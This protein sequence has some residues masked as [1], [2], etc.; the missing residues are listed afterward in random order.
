MERV[1]A[2]EPRPFGSGAEPT[3]AAAGQGAVKMM[4]WIQIFQSQNFQHQ[5]K[6]PQL[7]ISRPRS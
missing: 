2:Y 1:R 6:S 3:N 5:P 4:C 7:L